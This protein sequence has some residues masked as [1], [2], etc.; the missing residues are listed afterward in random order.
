MVNLQDGVSPSNAGL[1][2]HHHDDTSYDTVIVARASLSGA[3]DELTI[4]AV[5]HPGEDVTDAKKLIAEE[6]ANAVLR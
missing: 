5:V 4:V 3:S 1:P 6:I 2:F